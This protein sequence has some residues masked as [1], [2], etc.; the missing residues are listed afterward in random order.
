MKR[1]EALQ[2]I[3]LAGGT[4]LLIHPALISCSEEGTDDPG[5]NNGSGDLIINMDEA[6]YSALKS[7]GGSVIVSGVIIANTGNDNYVALSSICTHQGCTVNYSVQTNR[8]PCPCH[9]SVF[10]ADGSVVNGPATAPL[11]R[12]TVT[13][14]GNILTIK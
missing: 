11:K 2:R 8:F 9:G 13:K 3:V 1:R 10:N 14:E 4:V 6:A 12:Y 5:G 7:P